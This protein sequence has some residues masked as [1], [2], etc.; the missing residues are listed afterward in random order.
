MSGGIVGVVTT[1]ARRFGLERD[2]QHSTARDLGNA[3]VRKRALG[4]LSIGW[5][6][7]HGR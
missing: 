2:W 7:R 4:S 1:L 5:Y 6:W 3:V